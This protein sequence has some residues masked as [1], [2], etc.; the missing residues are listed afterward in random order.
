MVQ[1]LKH[2]YLLYKMQDVTSAETQFNELIESALQLFRLFFFVILMT[3]SHFTFGNTCVRHTD[4]E[5]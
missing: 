2:T 3:I 4:I 1:F 5:I